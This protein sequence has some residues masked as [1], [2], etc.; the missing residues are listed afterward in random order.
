L[1]APPL[2]PL[3]VGFEPPRTLFDIAIPL[4][5]WAGEEGVTDVGSILFEESCV[6]PWDSKSEGLSQFPA[7]P[8][9]LWMN[10]G[11]GWEAEMARAMPWASRSLWNGNKH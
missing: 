9:P 10:S 2:P 1:P 4:V 8:R 5:V 11:R 3:Y 6:M 7:P